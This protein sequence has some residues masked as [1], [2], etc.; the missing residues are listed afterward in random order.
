ME[1]AICIKSLTI[2]DNASQLKF[3]IIKGNEYP[4]ILSECYCDF[5]G[6]YID[7]KIYDKKNR[8]IYM[9]VDRLGGYM[10]KDY[11]ISKADWRAKQIN[12]ILEE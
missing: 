2:K 12:K 6:D 1:V 8:F 10:F 3:E 11:F 5:E 9:N 7:A 4:V